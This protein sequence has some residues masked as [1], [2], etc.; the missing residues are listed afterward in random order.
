MMPSGDSGEA[1]LLT[2]QLAALSNRPA[3][4]LADALQ[5]SLSPANFA[6]LLAPNI[7]GSHVAG[8]NYW[9]PQYSITPEVGATD[10]SFNYLF[11][12][13]A[14]A[15][16]LMW[17]GLAAGGF[18]RKGCRTLALVLLAATLF[19]LGRYTPLFAFVFD[20]VP[21]F[22]FFRRPVDATFVMLLAINLLQ[23]WTAR[24]GRMGV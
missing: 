10:E 12:G 14:P 17:F 8:F 11:V 2:L 4:T 3:V 7:F 22:T 21:G 1:I 24:R 15:L 18:A 20:Y 16:V 5:A 19:A 13:I 6:T 23:R 9:G